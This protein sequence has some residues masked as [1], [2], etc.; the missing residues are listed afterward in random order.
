MAG[1]L[2]SFKTYFNAKHLR[3]EFVDA[4]AAEN[5]IDEP[6]LTVIKHLHETEPLNPTTESGLEI[7]LREIREQ[8]H[9]H[10]E[11]E[12]LLIAQGIEAQ[13]QKA[14]GIE[15]Q[16]WSNLASYMYV[17]ALNAPGD[18]YQER[19]ASILR[20][21]ANGTSHDSSAVTSLLKESF[22]KYRQTRRRATSCSLRL[23]SDQ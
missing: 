10:P 4:E 1:L 21:V 19:P 7:K 11:D 5:I 6:S 12:A 2:E 18:A 23:M 22:K 15:R 13:Y 17:N 8:A 14:S 16:A 20:D 3:D 9:Q